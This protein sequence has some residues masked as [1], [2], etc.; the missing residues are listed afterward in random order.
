MGASLAGHPGEFLMTDSRG[1]TK[2]LLESTPNTVYTH[3]DRKSGRALQNAIYDGIGDVI[4]HVDFKNHG[5]GA[6][7]GHGHRFPPGNPYPGHGSG[8]SH[9]QHAQL[10]AGWADLPAGILSRTPI[11]Q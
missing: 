5:P 4:G 10:P 11:G 9:I 3:I 6:T 2:P 8:S 1:F 7:S